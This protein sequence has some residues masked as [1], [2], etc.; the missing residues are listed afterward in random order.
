MDQLF[1]DQYY[2]ASDDAGADLEAQK[3]IDTKILTD[4]FD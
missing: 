4:N 2:N 3:D 1:G